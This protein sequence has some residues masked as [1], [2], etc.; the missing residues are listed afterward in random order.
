[1]ALSVALRAGRS[2][3]DIDA[4]EPRCLQCA[5]WSKTSNAHS[6]GRYRIEPKNRRRA[7][8]IVR[9]AENSRL[10]T[11]RIA[12]RVMAPARYHA[13]ARPTTVGSTLTGISAAV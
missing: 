8:S 9:F 4:G 1:M 11:I 12:P 3:T 6:T 2:V 5:R 10:I 7:V 13:V